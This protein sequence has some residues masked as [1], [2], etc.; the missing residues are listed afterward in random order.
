LKIQ[1]F[2]DGVEYRL[3]G[4][5]RIK[6]LIN[7]VIAEEGKISGDL[8]F[9]LTNDNSLREMNRK[10]LKHNYFTDVISF[11]WGEGRVVEGEVYISVDTVK[12][13]AQN[14]KVSYKS[15]ILRVI[16]H[17]T[18]HLLGYNDK[19]M[20]EKIEMRRLEDMWLERYNT[21]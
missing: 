5:G 4:W 21:D 2:Y 18:L 3:R 15:E 13:N 1:L 12:R 9:I 19:S 17:G 20:I 11:G 10:Y 16:I 6:E 14:Y 8:N 7:K